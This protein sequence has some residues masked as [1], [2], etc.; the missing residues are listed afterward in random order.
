MATQREIDAAMTAID[1]ALRPSLRERLCSLVCKV[2]GAPPPSAMIADFRRDIATLAQGL[3]LNGDIAGGEARGAL[4]NLAHRAGL[5]VSDDHDHDEWDDGEGYVEFDLA[6]LDESQ[7]RAR[8]GQIDDA[9]H[10][11]E[12]ALPEG[13]GD[14]A[15]RLSTAFRSAR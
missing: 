13:Y 1:K 11:L 15:E 9:L 6:Q 2:L 14:I 7:R 5:Y 12:R 8:Y 10:H 3:Q 4:E